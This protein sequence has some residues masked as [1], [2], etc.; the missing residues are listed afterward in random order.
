M[1]MG[2][3]KDFTV[4]DLLLGGRAIWGSEKRYTLSEILVR[5]QVGIGDMARLARDGKPVEEFLPYLADKED[6]HRAAEAR[7][8]WEREL[9]KELGNVI[10]SA[11]RWCDDLGFDP[12]ECIGLAIDAQ[13][14]FAAS[15]KPR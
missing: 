7:V 2:M 15:G 9:K 10:F 4:R 5:L 3:L 8:V 13:A 14:K 6:L 11:I 12:E 1:H